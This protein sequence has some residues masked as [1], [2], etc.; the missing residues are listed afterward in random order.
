MKPIGY[1]DNKE[2]C[3]DEA[4]KY[5]TAYELQRN[6]YGCYK[7]L[8]RNGWLYEAYKISTKPMNYWND[9]VHVVNE[10]KKYKT[11]VE[12]KKHS[13]SAYNAI[14]RNGW[15]EELFQNNVMNY[16]NIDDKIHVVYVYEIPEYKTCYV[17]RTLELK[18]R[19]ASHRRSRKHS[20]G[21]KTYDVLY[22]FCH[23]HNI[24]IPKP[25]IKE[26]R[27]NGNESLIKEDY[28]LK[29]YQKNGWKTLNIA[30]TG[31]K[32]GSLGAVMKWN[33]D[34]CREFAKN[35]QYKAEL[36]EANYSC[37]YQ[38]LKNGWFGEFGIKDKR[39]HPMH[40]WTKERCMEV[41]KSCGNL[42]EFFKEHNS[43]Y[44]TTKNKGWFD[45]VKEYFI[46]LNKEKE[47][48]IIQDYN[49]GMM[50]KDIYKKYN[51][52]RYK[53]FQIFENNNIE[54]KHLNWRNKRN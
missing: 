17:G 46:S 43:V 45:E 53:L 31:E 49:D 34:N 11:K 37:Y 44:L 30:K 52:T 10:I 50:L 15:L 28:W 38:C 42:K 5:R 9:K 33:Y 51:I 3:L 23:E 2:N 26:N 36:K 4:R 29:E 21:T 40:Y 14:Y 54:L 27:L 18:K 20:D 13:K 19:D 6:C 1:W 39:E 41:A 32:S 25:I 7:G 47:R 16:R 22:R 35:Y 8:K 48:N 12:L 24:E